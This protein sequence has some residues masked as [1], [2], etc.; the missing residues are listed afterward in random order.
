MKKFRSCV[1]DA[2]VMKD[3]LEFLAGRADNFAADVIRYRAQAEEAGEE[4]DED[5]Y[6]ME[7]AVECQAKADAYERLLTRLSK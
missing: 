2:Y 1:A 3:L 5:S 6:Y 4:H 7:S